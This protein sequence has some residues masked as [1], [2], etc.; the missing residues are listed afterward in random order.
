MTDD[1][2]GDMPRQPP[3]GSF[4]SG[5]FGSDSFGGGAP[6]SPL[7]STAKAGGSA[8]I[9]D[10]Q[11]ES[12]LWAGRID[13][14][15]WTGVERRLEASP[16]AIQKVRVCVENLNE[17]L[18]AA[19]LTNREKEKAKAIT[20]ALLKLVM[21]PEPEWKLV[22]QALIAFLDSRPVKAAKNA[23]WLV[24]LTAEGLRLIFM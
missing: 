11:T 15:D 2:D 5:S 1:R 8:A 6:G 23:A 21:S 3:P 20:E 12:K 9:G 16:V 10:G 7:R 17:A 13:S 18:D 19:G 24:G 22:A 14:A 4:G